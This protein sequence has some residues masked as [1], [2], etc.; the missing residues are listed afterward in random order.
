MDQT[1]LKLSR[2]SEL[3]SRDVVMKVNL[4]SVWIVSSVEAAGFTV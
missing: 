2:L 1:N 4:D 3:V